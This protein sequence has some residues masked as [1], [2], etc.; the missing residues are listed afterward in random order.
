MVNLQNREDWLSEAVRLIRPWFADL[1]ET[2]PENIKISIGWS[3]GAKGNAVGVCWP[4][5]AAADGSTNIFMTP[6]R[7]E[8]DVVQILGTIVHEMNHASDDCES[9]HKGHF[10]KL[11]RQLGFLGKPTSSAEKTPELIARLEELAGL[12]GP[13]PH[14]AVTPVGKEKTQKTYMI[15]VS[16]ECGY[17][18]RTTQKFL[19]IAVPTCPACGP[20]EAMEVEEK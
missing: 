1:G 19:D 13:F 11:N 5:R 17:T 9:Q 8:E 2:L 12:L 6:E 14:A 20:D 4:S 3:K 15:K 7:G 10:A 16:H 18:L